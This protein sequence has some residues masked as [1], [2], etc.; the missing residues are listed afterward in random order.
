MESEEEVGL[1]R[2]GSYWKGPRR[3]Q[4]EVYPVW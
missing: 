1:G 3:G 4:G 2:E